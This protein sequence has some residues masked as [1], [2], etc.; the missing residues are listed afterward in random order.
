MMTMC[1]FCQNIIQILSNIL[2]WYLDF[3]SKYELYVLCNCLCILICVCICLGW[4]SEIWSK[5]WNLVKILKFGQSSEIWSKCWY[6]VKIVKFDWNCLTS[7]IG[8][9]LVHSRWLQSSELLLFYTPLKKCSHAVSAWSFRQTPIP[10]FQFICQHCYADAL[11]ELKTD[12]I[13]P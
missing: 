1:K 9:E 7:V 12:V 5:L 10:V 2:F 13:W 8:R 4:N 6:L 3:L 11:N